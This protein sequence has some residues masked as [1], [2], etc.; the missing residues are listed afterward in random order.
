MNS[1]RYNFFAG[2]ATILRARA[3]PARARLII[4]L[5]ISQE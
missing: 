1:K 3:M 4:K 2:F 5:C